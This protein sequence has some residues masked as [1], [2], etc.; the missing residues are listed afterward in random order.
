MVSEAYDDKFVRS[1]LEAWGADVDLDDAVL[2]VIRRALMG[3]W[4]QEKAHQSYFQA[5]LEGINPSQELVE[6]IGKKLTQ[7]RGKVEGRVIAGLMSKNKIRHYSALV[8]ITIGKRTTDVPEYVQRLRQ[9][10]F[11]EYCYVNADLEQTA[12]LGYDRMLS[13][14]RS[15]PDFDLV[16]EHGCA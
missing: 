9:K 10:N 7:I 1:Q 5:I 13:L 14:G 4:T 6:R 16:Y 3:V 8:M 12:V 15:K 11:S 2:D